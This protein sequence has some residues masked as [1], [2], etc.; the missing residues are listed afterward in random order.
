MISTEHFRGRQSR[1][2]MVSC[3]GNI[4]RGPWLAPARV[5]SFRRDELSQEIPRSMTGLAEL[6]SGE[7]GPLLSGPTA[8]VT[9]L[10][11]YQVTNHGK[12]HTTIPAQSQGLGFLPKV[13]VVSQSA[14]LTMNDRSSPTPTKLVITKPYPLGT[15]HSGEPRLIAVLLNC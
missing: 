3:G 4:T 1:N 8:G 9:S 15:Q 13:K 5:G 12:L 2:K 6:H 14:S 10:L 11:P 7:S